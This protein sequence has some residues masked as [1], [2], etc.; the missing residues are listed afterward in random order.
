M[1]LRETIVQRIREEGPIS[2]HDFMEMALYY[3]DKGYYTSER[4]QI[5]MLGDYYT[6]SNLTPAFGAV[7]GRQLE[8]MWDILGRNEF[9]VLEFGAGTGLLCHD[10]LEYL[11]TNQALYHQLCYCIIERSPSMRTREMAH[12]GEKVEWYQSTQDISPFTGCILSNE[13]LDNFPVHQVVMQDELMEVYVDYQNEFVELLKPASEALVDYFAGLNVLLPKGFRTEVNLEVREWIGDVAACL[14]SGYLIT[15]DYGYPSTELYS[16]RRRA[17][18]ILCYNKHT[19]NDKPYFAVGEQDITSHINF[20]A[21]CHWGFKNDFLCC[22]LVNLANFLLALGFKDILRSTLSEET[23]LNLVTLAKKE[24]FLSHTLL[25]DM[26]RK[27]R[28][29]IQRK[30]IE[31]NDLT[32]LKFM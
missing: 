6:S 19:I 18:T 17:G 8:E 25:M 29:L 14:K 10:I 26:G 13:L 23:G 3:P 32:G 22:G 16:Q 31:P 2:F 5:G 4:N 30:G 21:L 12:L 27:F 11:K 28:V 7:I 9:T 15:I 24:A 1:Q 20:S